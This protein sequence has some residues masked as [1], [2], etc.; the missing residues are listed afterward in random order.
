MRPNQ[1]PTADEL[2]DIHAIKQLKAY[3]CHYADSGQHAEAFSQLFTE[4]AI[5][6][7]GEDGVFSGR[8]AIFEMYQSLWPHLRMNQHLVLNPIIEL[9]GTTAT[10]N[11]RLLQLMTTINPEGD[12]ALVAAGYYDEKYVK[13]D[14]VWLFQHIA[15]RVHFCC[16]AARGWSQEP[17]APVFSDEVLAALGLPPSSGA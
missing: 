11:W 8:S 14:G 15:A 4:D 9:D 3:Y 10:G 6:D 5:L 12:R 16:D 7:E 17:F 1:V 2:C 13:I